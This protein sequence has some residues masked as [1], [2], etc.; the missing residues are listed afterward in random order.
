MNLFGNT[1]K[2][3]KAKLEEFSALNVSLSTDNDQLKAKLEEL[4]S[5]NADFA[6]KIESLESINTAL[7]SQ[8]EAI[9][10]K[11][12][13]VEANAVESTSNFEKR[14]TTASIEIAAQAGHPPVEITEE[15]ADSDVDVV[16]QYKN[17]KDNKERF[18]FYQANK[19]ELK[20]KLLK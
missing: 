19:N 18:A 14:V 8:K 20:K 7:A 15:E 10:S 13:E 2:E 12:E 4:S 9:E 17:I 5:I 11:I 1:N 16:K 3:L 6:N